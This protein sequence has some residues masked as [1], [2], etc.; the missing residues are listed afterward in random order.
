[1][2]AE[3]ADAQSLHIS[4]AKCIAREIRVSLKGSIRMVANAFPCA[5]AV[6]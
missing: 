4:E 3:Q 6:E 5:L 1:M 2:R